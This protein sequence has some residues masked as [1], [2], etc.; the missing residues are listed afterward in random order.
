MSAQ[1]ELK[2]K[3]YESLENGQL[4]LSE[5]LALSALGE[6]IADEDLEEILK[7]IRFWDNRKDLFDITLGKVN[8]EQ[9]FLEWDKFGDF[10]D[11]NRIAN[12]KAVFALKS[13]VFKN[14]V[15]M[16]IESYRLSPVKDKE[17]LILLGQAFN[18]L[19]IL[20]K[21]VETLEYALSLSGENDDVRIYTL[22]GDLYAEAGEED[23]AMVMFNE[24][25]YKFPQLIDLKMIDFPPLHRL[26][27]MIGKDGFVDHEILEWVPVYGYLYNG[28]TARRNLE[29]KEY[30][31]LRD[32]I[33]EYEKALTIDKKVI[34]VIVPRLINYYIWVFDYYVFQVN[35]FQGA[36]KIIR[37]LIELLQS[38]PGTEKVQQKLSDRAGQLFKQLL[39]ERQNAAVMKE[40]VSKEPRS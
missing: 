18:E 33:R 8:G 10:C 16:L 38:C 40:P 24:A 15:D 1:L 3:I 6:N 30:I 37:R 26:A 19:G 28:L 36:E 39:N 13:Y 35:A 12:K 32:R 21:A 7:I 4:D 34:N 14:I 11:E 25:F 22:L 9:L 27:E 23:M 20:D 17:N 2:K 5:E 29:Y 31:S